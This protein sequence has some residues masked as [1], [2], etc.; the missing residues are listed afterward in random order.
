MEE[1]DPECKGDFD[2]ALTSAG[3]RFRDEGY[4]FIYL[5]A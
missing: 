1:S 2:D 3:I 4:G 5:D